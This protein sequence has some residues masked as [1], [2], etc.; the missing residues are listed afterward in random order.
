MHV[1]VSRE[2]ENN[3]PSF[4]YNNRCD[5]DNRAQLLR[6]IVG[7]VVQPINLEGRKNYNVLIMVEVNN[8]RINRSL[9]EFLRK[10]RVPRTDCIFYYY[11]YYYL[12]CIVCA[13]RSC[14]NSR[15]IMYITRII[16]WTVSESTVAVHTYMHV[17][18]SA[19]PNLFSCADHHIFETAYFILNHITIL[20][21]HVKRLDMYDRTWFENIYSSSIEK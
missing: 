14:I 16:S 6:T 12:S 5:I 8:K 15:I 9:A 19:V 18:G 21:A 3:H 1:C 4:Y 7:T 10:Q 11:C 20:F 2:G 17:Y 13:L